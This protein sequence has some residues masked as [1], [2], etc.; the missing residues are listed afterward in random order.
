VASQ[1]DACAPVIDGEFDR[2][3]EIALWPQFVLSLIAFIIREAL[4]IVQVFTSYETGGVPQH[5]RSLTDWLR[6]R[7]H[8]VWIA[9]TPGRLIGPALEAG[10]VSLPLHTMVTPAAG[11][12]ERVRALGASVLALRRLLREQHVDLVHAHETAPAIVAWLAALGLSVV[13]VQSCHGCADERFRQVA[14]VGRLLS[15]RLI[16]V[17]GRTAAQLEESGLP[18]SRIEQIGYAFDSEGAA[19]GAGAP[20]LRRRLLGSDGRAL[21]VSV[22]RLDHQKGL[23]VLVEAARRVATRRPGTRF[24][25]VGDGDLRR[26]LERLIECSGAGDLVVLAGEQRP[27]PYLS[28]A[29]LFV[30]ASRWEGLPYAVVEALRAGLPVVATSA[31]G[32]PE[33]VDD[34]VG[35]LVP[36]EDPEALANAVT[37]L[38]EQTATRAAMSRAA[39]ARGRQPDFQPGHVY[40]RIEGVYAS[41]VGGAGA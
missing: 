24:A 16:A 5:V 19:D 17:S 3:L 40:R 36:R 25:I 7:R 12:R 32:V 14:L 27:G 41:V 33:L 38:L 29:D 26:E 21:V 2:V 15:R 4:R 39:V 22:A 35:R 18:R 10:F 34:A 8:V 28:A 37:A 31:G 20:A 23:D 11:L 6:G 30:L 9:G 13:I 1:T